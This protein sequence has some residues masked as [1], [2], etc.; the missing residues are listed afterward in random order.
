MTN[1]NTG[2]TQTYQAVAVKT[3]LKVDNLD[4]TKINVHFKIFTACLLEGLIYECQHTLLGPTSPPYVGTQLTALFHTQP[5]L[6]CL[7]YSI[8]AQTVNCVF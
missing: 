6:K 3:A 8:A 1:G 4:C 5:L 7:V 2:I